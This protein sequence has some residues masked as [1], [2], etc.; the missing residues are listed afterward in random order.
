MSLTNHGE[1][2][3]LDAIYT[4]TNKWIGLFTV[5]PTEA[6]GGT[7]VSGGSYARKDATWAAAVQGAPSTKNPSGP[8]AF[9]TATAD[10]AAGATQIVAFGVFDASSAGNLIGWGTLTTPRNVLNGDTP[11]FA[12]AS[13]TMTMD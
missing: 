2:L 3:A 1:A 7:E 4:T 9:P 10:W 13:L 5:A 8:V 11:S 12:A 6:G